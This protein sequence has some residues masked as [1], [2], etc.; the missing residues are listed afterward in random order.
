M[1]GVFEL[2]GYRRKITTLFWIAIS[3]LVLTTIY[4]I[5]LGILGTKTMKMISY[6]YKQN[7]KRGGEAR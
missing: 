6:I 2:L 5:V 7:K 1:L 4:S 3:G